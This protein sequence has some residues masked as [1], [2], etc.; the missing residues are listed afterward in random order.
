M[1]NKELWLTWNEILSIRQ[2][3]H[4]INREDDAPVRIANRIPN[5]TRRVSLILSKAERRNVRCPL[6]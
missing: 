4:R 6:I 3:L 1:K 5:L 2:L